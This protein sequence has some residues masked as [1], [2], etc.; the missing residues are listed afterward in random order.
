MEALQQYYRDNEAAFFNPE[1]VIVDY[2]LLE[3]SDFAVSVDEALV[4]EQY[5]AVKDEYE[6]SEQARVSHILADS[7]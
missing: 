1:Q 2:I 5:E 3:G 4:E 7:S 6:V